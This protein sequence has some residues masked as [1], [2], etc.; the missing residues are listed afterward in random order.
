MKNLRIGVSVLL[1]ILLVIIIN[2]SG[3]A[4]SEGQSQPNVSTQCSYDIYVIGDSGCLNPP[5]DYC[6]N[7]GTSYRATTNPFNVL[8]TAGQSNTICINAG[9]SCIAVLKV[10]P[11]APC[12]TTSSIEAEMIAD[13]GSCEC[14]NK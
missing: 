2:F 11:S 14:F 9:N 1:I 3:T 7:G 4:F 12:F 10:T 5:Y 6:I 8:L 13:G